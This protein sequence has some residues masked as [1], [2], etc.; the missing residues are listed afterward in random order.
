MSKKEVLEL[1]R[2]DL[3]GMEDKLSPWC[4]WTKR[5]QELAVRACKILL[6]VK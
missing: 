3:P 2:R 4:P 5:E 6:G 1:L